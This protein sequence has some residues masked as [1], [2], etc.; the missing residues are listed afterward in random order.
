VARQSSPADLSSDGGK[1]LFT[2]AAE[3]E[4]SSYSTW[5]RNTDGSPPVRLGDGAA[6]ASHATV[7]GPHSVARVST[8]V[9]AAADGGG[10]ARLLPP[11]GILSYQNA[12]W[13][14]DGSAIVFTGIE[15]GKQQRIYTQSI[16]G[17]KPR[18]VS[19]EGIRMAGSGLV[20]PDGKSVI[21]TKG[22]REEITSKSWRST[23]EAPSSS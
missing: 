19:A 22:D 13:I 4:G 3:A 11:D 9:A 17:G 5:L 8:P 23:A 16:D 1:L 6:F 10:R 12:A 7:S 20:S 21:V 14:P 18:P 2:E 15:D